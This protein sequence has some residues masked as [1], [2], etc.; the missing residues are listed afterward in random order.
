MPP[1]ALT[2]EEANALLSADTVPNEAT[3]EAW[4]ARLGVRI[5]RTPWWA[6]TRTYMMGVDIEVEGP[7]SR[8]K[9]YEV[10]DVLWLVERCLRAKKE[11]GN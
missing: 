4:A 11:D 9:R 6:L 1:R 10:R 7:P 2:D 5:T 3:L 8:F